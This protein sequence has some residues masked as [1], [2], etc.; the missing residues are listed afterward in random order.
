MEVNY[1]LHK[2][3]TIFDNA[4][5]LKNLKAFERICKDYKNFESAKII[6]DKEQELDEKV[7]KVGTWGLN[8]LN[9]NSFTEV[10]WCNYLMK[11]FKNYITGYQDFHK[12]SGAWVI[13]DIQVLKYGVG[14]HYQ[15]HTDY[16]PKIARQFSC[17]FFV[18]DNYD[19]GDLC[20]KYPNSE[21][22]TKIKKKANRM[23]VWP[24]NF[25]YPHCVS[26]VTKGERYSV[27]A[28][29]R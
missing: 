18:N 12:V 25:L 21:K 24:S 10:L 22:I 14:G 11:H 9:T 23:I 7:R 16:S 17:I 4:L 6:G 27:V 20:F 15:F 19:G 26:P 8:N 5:P 29:A 13:D 1:D 28:W 3:I 2:Y